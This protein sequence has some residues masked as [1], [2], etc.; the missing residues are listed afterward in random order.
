M[1]SLFTKT[2]LMLEYEQVL[3][4]R[5]NKYR[6]ILD[7]M[8]GNHAKKQQLKISLERKMH[9]MQCMYLA[10]CRKIVDPIIWREVV[11]NCCAEDRQRR[12]VHFVIDWMNMDFILF[13]LDVTMATGAQLDIRSQDRLTVVNRLKASTERNVKPRLSRANFQ[14]SLSVVNNLCMAMK[15]AVPHS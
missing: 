2:P 6:E 13:G 1:E 10:A 11:G 12:L 3:D 4:E 9:Y 5:V 15:K 14:F 8:P 7:N